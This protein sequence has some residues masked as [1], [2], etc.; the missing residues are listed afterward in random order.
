[1]KVKNW[2]IREVITISPEKTIEDALQL[3]KI[4]SIRHLP[5]VE[6]DKLIGLVTGIKS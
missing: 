4:H 1:M 3:M 2:M 6:N 5:V